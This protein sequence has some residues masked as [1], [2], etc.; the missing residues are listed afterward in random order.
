MDCARVPYTRRNPMQKQ[1]EVPLADAAAALKKTWGQ[2]WKLV[3]T[4]EL[5]G[6]KKNGKWLVDAESLRQLRTSTEDLQASRKS[7]LVSA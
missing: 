5:K 4:G 2:A 3:L 7:Q 6:R 1:N